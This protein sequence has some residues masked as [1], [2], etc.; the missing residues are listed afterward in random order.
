M[1]ASI[2][3]R[4]L[5]LPFLFLA[6]LAAGCNEEGAP[7]KDY[8]EFRL[9]NESPNIMTLYV[10]AE[11]RLTVPPGK[12]KSTRAPAGVVEVSVRTETGGVVW[13][14]L[15]DVPDNAFAQYNVRK[16]GSIV[17][18]AG[19]IAVPYQVGSRKEQVKHYNDA[20]YAVDV[21]VNGEL[22]GV[23]GPYLY[24]TFNTPKGVVTLSFRKHGGKKLFAQTFDIPRN[25]FI[26]YRVLPNGTVI[27]TGGEVERNTQEPPSPYGPYS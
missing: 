26:A 8:G 6:V 21:L 4:L 7:A 17:T 16:D 9:S 20:S 3:R 12:L 24:G 13:K 1:K 2:I 15:A 10:G 11:L 27:A 22:L 23:V 5:S 25:A 19:N 18:S 14:Q